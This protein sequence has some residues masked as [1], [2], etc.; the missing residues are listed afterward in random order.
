MAPAA[1][2]PAFCSGVVPSPRSKAPVSLT[3]VSGVIV[4][5]VRPAI[6][7]IGFMVE[8]TGY[9]PAIARSKN[10]ADVDARG[11]PGA[12][13]IELNVDCEIRV[14]ASAAGKN[15]GDEPR[16]RIAPLFTFMA[17][18]APGKPFSLSALS[19]AC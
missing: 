9:P 16:P 5:L 17:T 3:T 10:G 1:A 2:P 18:N 12:P 15:A 13:K 14:F 19:P 7:V 11:S 4:P 6:V 8:P